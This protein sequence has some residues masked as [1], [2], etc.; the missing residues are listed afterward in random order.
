MVSDLLLWVLAEL[1]LLLQHWDQYYL[2]WR[3]PVQLLLQLECPTT[4]SS[5]DA[6]AAAA[7]IEVAAAA[8]SPAA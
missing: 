4:D 1:H 3:R 7:L 8:S 6:A 2:R 5:V